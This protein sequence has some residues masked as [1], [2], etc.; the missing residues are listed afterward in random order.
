MT[1]NKKTHF[2]SAIAVL[3]ACT[4]ASQASAARK[5]YDVEEVACTDPSDM[6]C[7]SWNLQTARAARARRA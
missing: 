5:A 7:L 1:S 2:A 6:V 4:L 3:L